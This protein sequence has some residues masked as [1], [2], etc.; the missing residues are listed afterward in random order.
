MKKPDIAKRIARRGHLTEAEAADR[1]D[2]TVHQILS[3]LRKGE[4]ASLPG[5]GKFVAGPK[6]R[7]TFQKEV[8][9]KEGS[10]K[11]G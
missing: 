7:V 11:N 5:L 2:R 1:F 10:R 8:A 4:E 6:G 3:S 9:G